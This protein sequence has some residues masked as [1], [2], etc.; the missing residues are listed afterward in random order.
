V[1]SLTGQVSTHLLVSLSA[2]VDW[3]KKQSV[4]HIL[5]LF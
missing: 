1:N 2:K 4:T 5:V 3:L